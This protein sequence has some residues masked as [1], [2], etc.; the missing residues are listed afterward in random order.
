VDPERTPSGYRKFYDHD[1]ERLKWVLRQQ[2]EHFLPLKVI[3]GRL[4]QGVT[5]GGNG[6][7]LQRSLLEH[8]VSEASVIEPTASEALMPSLGTS[9]RQRAQTAGDLEAPVE[10][11]PSGGPVPRSSVG[12]SQALPGFVDEATAPAAPAGAGSRYATSGRSTA[13]PD[14]THPSASELGTHES[15]KSSQLAPGRAPEDSGAGASAAGGRASPQRERA[16]TA[17]APRRGQTPE[18]AESGGR[19][20]RGVFAEPEPT[21][22]QPS[23]SRSSASG[24]SGSRLAPSAPSSR[25]EVPSLPAS[26]RPQETPAAHLGAFSGVSMTLDELGESSGLSADEIRQLE[27]YCLLA[28]RSVGGVTYYDENSLTIAMLAA[29]FARYGVEPRHL[30]LHLLAAQREAGFVEQIVLPLLKQRNP[31]S[32]QRA[33]ETVS[34]MARLGQELHNVLLHRALHELLGG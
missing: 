30:R 29:A 2:R 31:T 10:H 6:N 4:E 32:R 20:V 11:A 16:T 17:P 18:G 33:S 26:L 21:S 24:P 9:E 7:D 12:A 19:V 22:S 15:H 14:A 8:E 3:K 13:A 25:R 28:G 23:S 5:S 34:E 1:V 27:T